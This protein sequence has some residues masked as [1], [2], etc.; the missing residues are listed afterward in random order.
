MDR[1]KIAQE[2]IEILLEESEKAYRN[3]EL[4]LMRRYLEIMENIKEKY[5][6]RLSKKQKSKYCSKCRTI[7][8]PGETSKVRTHSKDE[9]ITYTCTE[10]GEKISYPLE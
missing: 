4:D 8:I 9:K 1:R 10:C 7:L 5:Q 3:E 2:R 6:I